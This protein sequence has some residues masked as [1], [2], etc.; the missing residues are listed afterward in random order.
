[1][2]RFGEYTI[3]FGEAI[4]PGSETVSFPTTLSG[5]TSGTTGTSYNYSTTGATSSAGHGIQYLFDW[6][7]S[8]ESDF[9]R[10]HDPG[11]FTF[12]VSQIY[13]MIRS[14]DRGVAA[15]L[16]ELDRDGLADNTLVMFTS[17]NGPQ[18]GGRGE[19]CTDRFN[20]GFAGAKTFVYEGGIRL[21]MVLRWPAGIDGG[22][23]RIDE[24]IHFTLWSRCVILSTSAPP[25]RRLRTKFK[26]GD[27]LSLPT[28]NC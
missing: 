4:P 15:V 27:L 14:M 24:M 8:Q 20:C 13:A 18:F 9:A 26:R 28:A 25:T 19:M 1:M 11:K 10:F 16:E 17:D 23:R 12:A 2:A 3:Y 21:P 7:E 5:T 6:G 22:G